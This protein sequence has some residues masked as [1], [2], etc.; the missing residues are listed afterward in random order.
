MKPFSRTWWNKKAK[1]KEEINI[2][3]I[4]RGIAEIRND[5]YN[6]SM[7]TYRT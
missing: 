5:W 7:K 1:E 3:G 6:Q 4:V 2:G